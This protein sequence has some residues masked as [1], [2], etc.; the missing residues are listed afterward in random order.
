[1]I[2]VFLG[3]EIYLLG[4]FWCLCLLGRLFIYFSDGNRSIDH[5]DLLE[6]NQSVSLREGVR[7]K[8]A[9]ICPCISSIVKWKQQQLSS[10]LKQIQEFKK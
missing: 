2:D 7:M 8:A 1:M 3:V 4:L 6:A 10:F 5:E 9:T